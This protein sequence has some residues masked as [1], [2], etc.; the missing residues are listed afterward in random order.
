MVRNWPGRAGA[1]GSPSAGVSRTEITLAL[2]WSIATTRSGRSPSQASAAASPS[3]ACSSSSRNDPCQPSLSAGIRSARARSRRARFGRYSKPS[4]SATVIA[5]GP[6]L[7]ALDRV[8]CPDLALLED[9]EIEAGSAVRDEQRRHPRLVHADSDAIAR[10]PRLADLE[11]RRTDAVA[12]ADAD[13]VIGEPVDGEV[14]AEL[15]VGEIVAIEKLLPVAVGLDLVD[16]HGT[17]DAA[18]AVQVALPVAVDVEATDPPPT[19]DGVLPDARVDG[20]ALPLDIA[21]HADV[22]RQQPTS[23]DSHSVRSIRP[24]LALH[25]RARHAYLTILPRDRT[26][27]LTSQRRSPGRGSARPRSVR[28]NDGGRCP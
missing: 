3:G 17:V 22:H 7:D 8:A 18:V 15:A 16:E 28:G 25:V 13:L 11:Q 14:L 27:T 26:D 19:L 2:S 9:A 21:R 23:G 1:A 4:I 6:R 20:P 10:D 5:S 24:L 12:V